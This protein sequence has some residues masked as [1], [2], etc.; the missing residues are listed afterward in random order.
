MIPVHLS[1]KIKEISNPWSPI[2]VTTVND[3]VVRLALFD[4]S[5]HWHKHTHEDELFYV[6]KGDIVIQVKGKPDI[7]VHKGEM[8]VIPKNVEHCPKGVTP[9]YVLLIEPATLLSR[10]D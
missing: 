9:S 6:L 1:E 4:G 3:H 2:D 10:G 5:Y 8:V 7:Q